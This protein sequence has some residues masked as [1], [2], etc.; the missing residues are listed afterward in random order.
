M[1][2]SGKYEKMHKSA[3]KCFYA[4]ALFYTCF[5]LGLWEWILQQKQFKNGIHKQAI[6]K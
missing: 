3:Y 4:Q 1:K 2:K 6:E 5:H